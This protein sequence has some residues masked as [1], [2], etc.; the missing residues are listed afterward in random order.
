MIYV[1][2]GVSAQIIPSRFRISTRRHV[3]PTKRGLGPQTC[4]EGSPTVRLTER[5]PKMPRMPPG[6][7]SQPHREPCTS[8]SPRPEQGADT[9]GTRAPRA[10][11]AQAAGA[12]LAARAAR[13]PARIS[14]DL[15]SPF[16]GRESSKLPAYGGGQGKV[17]SIRGGSPRS[18][19]NTDKLCISGGAAT[20]AIYPPREPVSPALHEAPLRP[21]PNL[22]SPSAEFFISAG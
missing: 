16:A 4:R 7:Q 11:R 5:P 14:S 17:I 3:V 9:P 22:P 8:W 6:G 2:N 13:G 21:L 19:A 10:A 12:M 1:R 15:R 18:R 20:R